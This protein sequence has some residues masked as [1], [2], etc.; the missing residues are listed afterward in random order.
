LIA[1][2]TD[3]SEARKADKAEKAQAG[4]VQA[5]ADDGLPAPGTFEVVVREWLTTQHEVKVSFG[6]A[7]R[8]HIRLEQD[9]F[10]W[11]GRRPVGEIEP[12][13]LPACL[14]RIEARGAIETA[15]RVK[16]ACGQVLR[17]AIA[18]GL[19]QRATRRPT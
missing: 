11:I 19:C 9:A 6:H 5:L 4:E 1:A 7:E 18:I 2:R 10:P 17:N 3:P 14:R 13:E 12:P 16:D 15:H 8:T